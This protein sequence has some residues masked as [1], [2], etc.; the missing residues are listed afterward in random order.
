[1]PM[2]GNL[3]EAKN[4]TILERETREDKNQPK[5]KFGSQEEKYLAFTWSIACIGLPTGGNG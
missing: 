2:E 5:K 1:M 4:Q 3:R